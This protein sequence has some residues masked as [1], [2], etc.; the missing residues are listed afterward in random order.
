MNKHF[1]RA[2]QLFSGKRD[3]FT[4]KRKTL[5]KVCNFHLLKN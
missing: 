3:T 4:K 2:T 1:Q 5:G